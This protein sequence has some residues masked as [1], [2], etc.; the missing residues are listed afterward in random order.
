MKITINDI[1]YLQR[2][3]TTM[4]FCTS[5]CVQVFC[6]LPLFFVGTSD[7]FIVQFNITPVYFEGTCCFCHRII[8]AATPTLTQLYKYKKTTFISRN[9]QLQ[10]SDMVVLCT[11]K[12]ASTQILLS[13]NIRALTGAN[14]SSTVKPRFIDTRFN[15]ADSIICPWGKKA[16]T[17]S[18][19]S[20]RLIRTPVNA[21][22]GTCNCLIPIKTENS[23]S[24]MRTV[25]CQLCAEIN[26]S[27]FSR[28]FQT[29]VD[30]L[31]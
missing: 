4:L 29:T 24:L 23:T 12:G 27:F 14:Q 18:L 20:T 28:Q 17:F 6:V 15:Y 5:S 2:H 3:F 26:L 22:T 7:F 30:Y 21:D 19:N 16:L 1:I 25:H 11:V 13:H 9:L 10:L 31:H 8:Q